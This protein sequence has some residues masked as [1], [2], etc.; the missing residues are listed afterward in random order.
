M[1]KAWGT[2]I[3]I[4]SFSKLKDLKT[5]SVLFFFLKQETY[6]TAKDLINPKALHIES[7]S[8]LFSGSKVITD[9]NG[10][11]T[12]LTLKITDHCYDSCA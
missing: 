6:I 2:W 1:L 5:D 3:S 7:Q 12:I 8:M 11:F 10:S 4:K 9:A